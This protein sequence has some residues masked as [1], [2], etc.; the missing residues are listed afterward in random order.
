M[1]G[2][3]GD[4]PSNPSRIIRVTEQMLQDTLFGDDASD[5]MEGSD[6]YLDAEDIEEEM[7]DDDYDDD[8]DY[9]E[10]DEEFPQAFFVDPTAGTGDEDEDEDEDMDEDDD[11][12]D[13]ED[14][15]DGEGDEIDL[16]DIMALLNSAHSAEARSS[17]LAQLLRAPRGDDATPADNSQSTGILR[18]LG[19]SRGQ[20][21]EDRT[22]SEAERRKRERWWKPQLEPHPA[23]VELLS[24]GEFGRVRGWTGSGYGR[25]AT[26]RCLARNRLYD[27]TPSIAQVSC[28]S[29]GLASVCAHSEGHDPQH[30]RYSRSFLPQYPI[31]GAICW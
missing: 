30:P 29:I 23:G 22:R 10:D 6:F 13:Y 12:D 2:T 1:S 19:F 26:R 8:D 7:G 21:A 11:D 4:P 24:S 28:G 3:G 17:I 14:V 16:Q 5:D 15:E 25:R 31:R 27:W 18:R 20:T 9:D